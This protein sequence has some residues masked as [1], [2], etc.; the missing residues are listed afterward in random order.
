MMTRPAVADAINAVGA[1][2]HQLD[3]YMNML[4]SQKLSIIR[5]QKQQN[6]ETWSVVVQ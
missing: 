3:L 1:D 6:R 2:N 5:I 4:E